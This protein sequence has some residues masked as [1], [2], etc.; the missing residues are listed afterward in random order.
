MG[1]K[2]NL[3][4]INSM[5]NRI[6]R[7]ARRRQRE[8]EKQSKLINK[9]QEQER[10][11]YEVQVYENLIDLLRS[12]HKECSEVYNWSLIYYHKPPNKPSHKCVNELAAQAK[13]DAYK[14]GLAD[15]LFGGEKSK[16]NDLANAVNEARQTDERK[17]QEEIRL[18]EQKYA[19]WNA[20][21][22]IA[23]RISE[24]KTEAYMEAIREADPFEDIRELGSSFEFEVKNPLLVHA[25]IYVHGE[26]VIP[27]EIKSQ[28]KSGKLAV[29]PMP[30]GKFYELY[31]DY[32]CGFTL[33]VARELFSLLPIDIVI[34]TAIGNLLNT[35]TGNLE[36]S[37]ILS[38][39]IPRSTLDKLNFN[40]IDPSDAMS[41]F[42]HQMDFR[43]TKGF[44]AVKR[45]DLADL[46]R[47]E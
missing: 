33:R 32:V 8:L 18:Y 2:G 16:R 28:L 35:Q 20:L 7:D 22:E 38:A 43:K 21:H 36:D 12:V 29:K 17:Y 24:G 1:W 19:E 31:Q 42:V 30:K 27:L 44:S 4:T 34:V 3:R 41:N 14:P 5:C 13:L 39:I 11:A 45:L 26:E 9:M 25:N 10:A 15:K 23:G 37:P 47:T 40:M 46:N 6:E